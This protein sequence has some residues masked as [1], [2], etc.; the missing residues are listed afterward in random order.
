[1]LPTVKMVKKIRKPYLNALI[2]WVPLN[3]IDMLLFLKMKRNQA[4][5]Q[6]KAVGPKT[7]SSK[8]GINLILIH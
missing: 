3:F 1:M 6:I 2:V 8:G 4:I 5:L 7:P